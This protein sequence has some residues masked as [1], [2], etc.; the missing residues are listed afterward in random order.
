M[1]TDPFVKGDGLVYRGLCVTHELGPGILGR[2]LE[3]DGTVCCVWGYCVG[4]TVPCCWCVS[5]VVLMRGEYCFGVRC[6]DRY[7][8][9]WILFCF[10]FT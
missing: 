4:I 1:E 5:A 2:H 10:E 9:R 3:F 6:W 8:S 7:L